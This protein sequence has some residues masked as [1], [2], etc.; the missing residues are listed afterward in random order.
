M[1][2]EFRAG[3]SPPGIGFFFLVPLAKLTSINQ[4]VPTTS[5]IIYGSAFPCNYNIHYVMIGEKIEDQH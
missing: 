1:L 5:K 2:Q 4:Q 3:A